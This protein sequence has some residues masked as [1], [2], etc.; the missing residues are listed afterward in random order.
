MRDN[1]AM[2]WMSY[3]VSI[4][5]GVAVGI[6]YGMLGVRSPA[7]PLVALAGLLGML[8]GEMLVGHYRAHTTTQSESA[9]PNNAPSSLQAAAPPAPPGPPPTDS[10]THTK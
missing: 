4:A 6:V 1:A 5:I 8:G 3:V 7:P 2:G 10:R 9:P